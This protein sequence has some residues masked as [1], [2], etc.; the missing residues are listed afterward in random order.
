MFE[1]A[2]EVVPECFAGGAAEDGDVPEDDGRGVD[3]DR[4]LLAFDDLAG[5]FVEDEEFT[6][7]CAEDSAV[8]ASVA[9]KLFE[10]GAHVDGPAVGTGACFHQRE[11][12]AR[13]LDEEDV[14]VGVDELDSAV[15]ADLGEASPFESVPECS[16]GAEAWGVGVSLRGGLVD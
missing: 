14:V 15:V 2:V 12:M 13:V 3:E 10:I 5:C 1:A 11:D 8:S 7:T 4:E 6:F 9:D 16:H